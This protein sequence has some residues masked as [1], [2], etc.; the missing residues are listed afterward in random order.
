[1]EDT[2]IELKE[3]VIGLDCCDGLIGVRQTNKEGEEDFLLVCALCY[4]I[5]QSTKMIDHLK[6]NIHH[7]IK[8]KYKEYTIQMMQKK[9][10]TQQYENRVS[11]LVKKL[12]KVYS[13]NGFEQKNINGNLYYY[14]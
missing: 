12:Y 8:G 14:K 4:F 6:T 7:K 3:H 9:I 11:E 1:M 2:K 10:T 13:E 5:T